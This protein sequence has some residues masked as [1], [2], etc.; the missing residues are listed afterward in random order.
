ML[1][2]H[3][4]IELLKRGESVRA[5]RRSQ[6]DITMVSHVFDFYQSPHF[7]NI[8]WVE[9]DVLDMYSLMDAMIGCTRVFHCAA[10]V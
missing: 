4:M 6:S 10:I 3:I 7:S 8:E 2:T 5:L 1:G 9:G